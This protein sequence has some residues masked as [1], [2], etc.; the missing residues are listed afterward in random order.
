MEIRENDTLCILAPLSKKLDMYE[1]ER[2]FSELE[3]ESRQIA[4]DLYHVTDCTF[5][6]LEHLQLFSIRKTL[7][8][9]NIPADIFVLFNTMSIDKTAKLFVSELDFIENSR[10]ILNRKFSLIY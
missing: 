3:K 7:G 1:T 6:F 9:F 8:I 2:I 5:E 10:Q 4:I